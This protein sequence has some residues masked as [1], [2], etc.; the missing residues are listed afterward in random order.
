MKSTTTRAAP[1][2]GRT[3]SYLSRKAA[4][5]GLLLAAWAATCTPHVFASTVVTG[6]DLH[7]AACPFERCQSAGQILCQIIPQC[8]PLGR[9]VFLDIPLDPQ[10]SPCILTYCI[11][12]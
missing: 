6:D 5:V 1:L 4:I 9:L 3:M 8:V 2:V 10:N 11:A 12:S 7:C